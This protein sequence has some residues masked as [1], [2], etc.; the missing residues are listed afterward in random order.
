MLVSV[1]YSAAVLLTALRI[2]G[3]L[4][5]WVRTNK[6]ATTTHKVP[7]LANPAKAYVDTNMQSA[8][9]VQ[10][11]CHEVHHNLLIAKAL[12]LLGAIT[13][14]IEGLHKV[15]CILDSRS[16]IVFISKTVW[17]TLNQELNPHWKITMQSANGSCNESL[18]PI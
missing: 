7:T 4:L 9:Q 14:K 12:H 15:E 17:Q 16:Q 8:N 6:D 5:T 1:V 10:L 2:H 18:G 11:C 13:P 3:P